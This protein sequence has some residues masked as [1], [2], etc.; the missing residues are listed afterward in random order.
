[1]LKKLHPAIRDCDL[2]SPDYDF[3]GS[4]KR[5][6]KYKN[7]SINLFGINI[8]IE[9]SHDE[10]SWE[11][12]S[13]NIITDE[14]VIYSLDKFYEFLKKHDEEVAESVFSDE[15]ELTIRDI[16][17]IAN[18]NNGRAPIFY[19]KDL[20]P[21]VIPKILNYSNHESALA[22]QLD[23]DKNLTNVVASFPLDELAYYY[24]DFI[25]SS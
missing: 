21:Y 2:N 8:D 9:Y 20:K 6:K 3:L 23:D 11:F 14:Q 25:K 24:N 5:N 19:G 12:R 1:M 17:D 18:S 7:G 22:I 16:V 10:M 4:I 13:P 15:I